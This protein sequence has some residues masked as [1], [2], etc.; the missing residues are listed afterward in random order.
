MFPYKILGGR[1]LGS[2]EKVLLVGSAVN[3]STQIEVVSLNNHDDGNEGRKFASVNIS[4]DCSA[5]EMC[6]VTR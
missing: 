3:H 1:Y 6:G 4:G 2:R 5:M